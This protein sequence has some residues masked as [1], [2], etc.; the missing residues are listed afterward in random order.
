MRLRLR[1]ILF[2]VLIMLA[3]FL[4]IYVMSHLVVLNGFEKLENSDVKTQLKSATDALNSQ[5]SNLDIF[6]KNGYAD[7]D[8]S[9]QFIQDNNTNYI[10]QNLG[11]QGMANMNINVIFYVNLTGQITYREAYNVSGESESQTLE[12]LSN[13]ILNNSLLWKFS[14]NRTVLGGVLCT[15]KTMFMI[16]SAPILTSQGGGPIMGALIMGRELTSNEVALLENMT[17]LQISLTSL[18]SGNLPNNIE[19]AKPYLLNSGDIYIKAVNSSVIYGYTALPSVLGTPAVILQVGLQRSVYDEGVSTVNNYIVLTSLAVSIFGLAAFAFLERDIISRIGKMRTYVSRITDAGDIHQRDLLKDGSLF[20]SNDEIS[21][22]TKAINQMLDRI[23]KMTEQL[24]K[25]QKLATIGEL[26]AM[27][28]H[29]LRNPLT[30]IKN[31]SYFLEK[32]GATISEAQSKEMFDAINKCIDHSNKIINDLLDYSRETHLEITES[33]P[34]LLLSES[35]SMVNV[36]TNVKIVNNVLHKKILKVDADKIRRVFTN[37][38]KNSIDAMPNG[39]TITLNCKEEKGMTLI[40]VADTGSGIPDE[41]LPKIFSPLFTTKAQGMGFGLAICKRFVEAHGG[42]IEVKTAK[43]QGTTFI[44]SL[45]IEPVVRT[46]ENLVT[47]A[48]LPFLM[49]AKK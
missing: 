13:I 35:L 31:A 19:V 47:T 3:A 42:S 46:E 2:I 41:T 14:D 48:K 9:C 22:L 11:D 10:T 18:N 17:N 32:K 8:D 43:E 20:K 33:S 34:R 21:A 16:S 15:S 6:L 1:V 25:S 26:A 40:S 30:G 37:L 45:P 44:V 49:M 24:N 36:P 5:I 4:S 7:W 23:Q 27:V 28:G 38:I 39:G 12:E 29:D